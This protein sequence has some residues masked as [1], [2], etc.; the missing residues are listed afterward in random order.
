MVN[1]NES[2]ENRKDLNLQQ[3]LI[4][5]M[6]E[7]DYIQREDIKVN[8]QY[9]PVS[10]NAVIKKCRPILNKWGVVVSPLDCVSSSVMEFKKKGEHT[11]YVTQVTMKYL[12]CNADN[13]TDNFVCSIP[14]AGFDSLDKGVNKA[15]TIGEKQL[16]IILLHIEVGDE[17]ESEREPKPPVKQEEVE[18]INSV[19]QGE[20]RVLAAKIGITEE[21]VAKNSGHDIETIAQIPV[22]SFDHIKNRLQARVNQ[23][24]K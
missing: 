20:I 19:Q 24:K 12:V 21:L 17:D 10:R 23:L 7:V 2:Y 4:R 3:R 14:S 9:K 16:F 5:V 6:E 18:T 22:A 11:G 8:N 15:I 13:P 1:Y